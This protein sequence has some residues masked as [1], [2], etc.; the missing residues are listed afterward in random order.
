MGVG[1]EGIGSIAFDAGSVLGH[2]LSEVVLGDEVD[3]ELVFLE[4]DIGMVGDS[5]QE[6]ALDFGTGVVFMVQDAE[7][8]VPSFAVEVEASAT[9]L[10]EVDAVLHKLL[11]TFG[12]FANGH[13]HHFAVADAVA[14]DEGVLDM[15]VE[16]VVIVHHGG[17]SPL[18]IF[19][20]AFG[21]VGL[22][23]DAHLAVVGDFQGIAQTRYARTND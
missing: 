22:G 11:D 20:G 7:F 21:G 12:S 2:P 5:L 14:G 15:F 4:F 16:T 19:G 18:G 3:G 8:A 10:V 9:V 23:E 6:T 17:D 13:L 1:V